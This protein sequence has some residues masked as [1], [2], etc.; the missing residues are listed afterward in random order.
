ML[1]A[2]V[3]AL[4]SARFRAPARFVALAGASPS[5]AGGARSFER[6]ER[7]GAAVLAV[8]S[9]SR[10]A[11]ARDRPART[12]F[13]GGLR[14]W[15]TVK[16]AK[17]AFR[18]VSRIQAR[19]ICVPSWWPGPHAFGKGARRQHWPLV[20]VADGVPWRVGT[21]IDPDVD[22]MAAALPGLVAVVDRLAGG[23][24]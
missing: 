12:F 11:L 24:A 4:A 10:L 13:S 19:A 6:L 7:S 18:Q 9:L 8:L 23:T 16:T 2:L 14:S 20:A 22:R 5:A 3:R 15:S 1:L 21:R 17:K